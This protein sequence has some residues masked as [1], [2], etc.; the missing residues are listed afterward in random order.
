M[1]SLQL[2]AA[3]KGLGSNGKVVLLGRWDTGTL[4]L[5][6]GENEGSTSD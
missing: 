3:I 4:E 1:F 6:F 2:G 5:E